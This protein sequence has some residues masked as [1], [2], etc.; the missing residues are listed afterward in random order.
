MFYC[1]ALF[2]LIEGERLFFCLGVP[3]LSRLWLYTSRT[4]FTQLGLH[5]TPGPRGSLR[6]D[7][8]RSVARHFPVCPLLICWCVFWDNTTRTW[9]LHS[10][11]F[12]LCGTVLSALLIQ[13][14]L[15]H[16]NSSLNFLAWQCPL[17][18]RGQWLPSTST[19]LWPEQY[20]DR[21]ADSLWTLWDCVVCIADLMRDK[22]HFMG[23]ALL[24][25][26]HN[27]PPLP[28][29]AHS[30]AVFMGNVCVFTPQQWWTLQDQPQNSWDRSEICEGGIWHPDEARVFQAAGTGTALT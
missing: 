5:F 13:L 3:P 29:C 9:T 20:T 28:F 23:I 16:G 11:A 21:P 22:H 17:R 26:W 4:V 24:T 8:P 18:K 1:T 27:R 25:S 10:K 2:K 7:V 19:L 30:P 14:P 12:G 6:N 15:F